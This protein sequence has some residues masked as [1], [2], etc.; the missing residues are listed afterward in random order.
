MLVAR[1]RKN[2]ALPKLVST[3]TGLRR[4][5]SAAGQHVYRVENIV[6]GKDGGACCQDKPVCEQDAECYDG[7]WRPLP[8][9]KINGSLTWRRFG[10][11]SSAESDDCLVQLKRVGFE[12]EDMT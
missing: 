8:L 12:D 11:E 9:F 5:V 1:V 6:T 7:V 2:G 4:V 10:V 3:W